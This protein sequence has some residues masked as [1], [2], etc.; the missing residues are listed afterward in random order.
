MKKCWNLFKTPVLIFL[1]WR[2]SLFI[3]SYLGTKVVPVFGNMYP[4]ADTALIT[5]NLPPWVWGF[6][7][8]DGVHYL[9]IAQN[10]YSDAFYQAFFPLFPKLIGILNILPRDPLLD[11]MVYVDK[12]YFWVG[13][14]FSNILLMFSLLLIKE[15]K[16]KKNTFSSIILLLSFPTTYY[17]GAIYSESLFLLLLLLF[18]YCFRK[19]KYFLAGLVGLLASATKIIGVF[20]FFLL[21]IKFFEYLKKKRK[22]QLKLP[23]GL[24]LAPLGLLGYMFFLWRN[25]ANPILFLTSQPGFGAQRSSIPIVTLPQVFVRYGKMLMTVKDGYQLFT[26]SNEL[27]FSISILILIIWAYKKIDI[28]TWL[29]SLLIFITPTLTGTLSSMPRYVIFSYVLLIPVIVVNMNKYQKWVLII[30]MILLQVILSVLFT[31]GYWVA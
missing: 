27:I 29:L 28:Y 14:L 5:S 3:I 20:F 1:V 23:M 25:Y 11:T 2:V 12:T 9:R 24:F 16:N 6:G 4:Y 7:G 15:T 19:E 8:F 10:G 13:L 17:F 31:R 18:I 22:I 26:I 21:F 30:F